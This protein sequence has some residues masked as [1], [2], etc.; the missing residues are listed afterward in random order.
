MDRIVH[1]GLGSNLGDR[2][3]HLAFAMTRLCDWCDR[4]G[5]HI[6]GRSDVYETM[7][8]PPTPDQNPYLNAVLA[9]NTTHDL[10]ELLSE[11]LRIERDAGRVRGIT[12]NHAREL[13]LDILLA[14]NDVLSLPLLTIPHPRLHERRF[15]LE[16][17]ADLAPHLFHPILRRRIV[18]LRNDARL[19]YPDQI[20]HRTGIVLDSAMIRG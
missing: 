7:P 15:V 10:M 14:G 13:D 2:Q 16:P 6:S 5:A 19:R 8:V 12:R 4:T 9:M 20:V 11:L 17:L 3:A 1:I 18:D